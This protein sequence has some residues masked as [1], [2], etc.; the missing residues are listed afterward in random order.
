MANIMKHGKYYNRIMLACIWAMFSLA[1]I[2]A[3]NPLSAQSQT[4]QV[5][6]VVKGK[7][8][9]V[10]FPERI[11]TISIANEAIID[12]ATITPTDAVVIGK[13]EG[14]TS[15]YIWGE[16]GKY[17]AYEMKVDRSVTSQQIVL[18]VQMAE[19]NTSRMTDFGVDWLLRDTDDRN[20]AQGEKILGS[21]SGQVT[22]PD[23][24]SQ[25]LYAQEGISG[26]I[27]WVG[28]KHTAQMMIRALEEKGNLKML[29]NPRLVCLSN[30]EASFLVGGEIPVPIAQQSSAG[31]GSAITIEW[32][33]FGVKLR[34]TP[35]IVDTN[36]IRL[37]IAPEVSSLDYSNSVSFGGWTIPAIRTRKAGGTV[38]LNSTQAIVL[39]GLHASET[40]ETISRIPILG[41]IPVLEFFFS[42]KH[43]VTS[44]NELLII[45][46]PRIIESAAQEVVPPLPGV[47]PDSTK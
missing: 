4:P 7:S 20:I 19:V 2:P 1:I 47:A 21:Y 34:F 24:Q 17:L 26:V 5:L 6:R 22:V 16:S 29:A 12:V 28:D 25:N 44:D 46:S 37:K 10:T 32:K 33:E 31:G 30:E 38:E 35:T 42:K 3:V 15:L 27:K 43:K 40:Q 41:H 45:V 9:V 13:D 18:E 39:G 36:L 11:K 14:I 8:I 23:P